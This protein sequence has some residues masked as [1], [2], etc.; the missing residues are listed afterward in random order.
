MTMKHKIR[1]DEEEIK[2]AIK[3]YLKLEYGYEVI[4]RYPN[5]SPS[6]QAVK[7]DRISLYHSDHSGNI[8]E[9]VRLYAEA[10][11]E[12]EENGKKE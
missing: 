3:S 8:K 11:V 7:E 4:H 9:E 10:E 1:L 5:D 2:K 12:V 6:F